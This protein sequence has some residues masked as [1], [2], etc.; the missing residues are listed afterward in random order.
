MTIEEIILEIAKTYF[1]RRY[2]HDKMSIIA[3]YKEQLQELLVTYPQLTVITE[4][5]QRFSYQF[6]YL[7]QQ[8]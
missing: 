7:Y 4:Y 3:P 5:E 2:A 6:D 1:I 8:N